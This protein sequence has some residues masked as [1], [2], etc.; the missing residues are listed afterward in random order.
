MA[1]VFF[2]NPPVLSGTTEEQLRQMQSYLFTQS[3]KLNEA[4]MNIGMDQ[5]EKT[6]KET[7]QQLQE[8]AEKSET[9]RHG[10]KELIIK[11][12]DISRTEED[13]I[14]AQLARNVTALS[15]AFGEFQQTITA[16]L[17]ATA[18]GIRQTYEALQLVVNTANGINEEY[19][20]RMSSFIFS[21]VLDPEAD[22]PVTGIAIG[23]NVTNSDGTL[24]DENKM[25]TF[26][27]DRITFYNNNVAIGYYEGN[28]FHI[29]KGEVDDSMKIANFIFKKFADGSM[30]LMKE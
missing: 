9:G 23:Q 11:N 19:R 14:R 27:A 18:T 6:G 2:E 16:D 4:L 12:A 30:G 29:S 21:G 1:N 15:E 20:T 24:N 25:A 8:R 10:L 17:L 22:P 5:L 28:T 3:L 7:I 26:T 13:E